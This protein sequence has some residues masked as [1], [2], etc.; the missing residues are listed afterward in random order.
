MEGT[1]VD[2]EPEV[3]PLEWAPQLGLSS[4]ETFPQ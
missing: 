4:A 2:P 3:R 1:A